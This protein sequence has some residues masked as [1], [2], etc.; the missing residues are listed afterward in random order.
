MN[1]IQ[2][3]FGNPFKTLGFEHYR[4][5]ISSRIREVRENLGWIL[6]RSRF[7]LEGTKGRQVDL[8]APVFDSSV[9][10][11]TS[12]LWAGRFQHRYHPL[13]TTGCCPALRESQREDAIAAS[14]L[15]KRKKPEPR[16]S[17]HGQGGKCIDL[18]ETPSDTTN[19]CAI[20]VNHSA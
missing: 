1:A 4:V 20:P 10:R 19:C 5:A 6:E 18:D 15:G 14:A 3:P 13:Q 16:E 7:H 17:L 8:S 12:T 11:R 9:N 2:E